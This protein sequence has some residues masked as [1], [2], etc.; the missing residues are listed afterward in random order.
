M[1]RATWSSRWS[2]HSVQDSFEMSGSRW[3]CHLSLPRVW[4][5]GLG[6]KVLGVGTQPGASTHRSDKHVC[7]AS[8]CTLSQ[9]ASGM[10]RLARDSRVCGYCGYYGWHLH[11]L[12]RLPGSSAAMRAHCFVPHFATAS[13]T[14]LSSCFAGAKLLFNVLHRCGTHLT[15]CGDASS[16]HTCTSHLNPPLISRWTWGRESWR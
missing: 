9:H 15:C 14:F 3:L 16:S 7:G 13:V 6:A 5:L 10:S 11:C 2:S 8:R 4:G 12:P 1:A